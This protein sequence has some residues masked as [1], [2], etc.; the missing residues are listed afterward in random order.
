MPGQG[1]PPPS[2]MG[3]APPGAGGGPEGILQMLAGLQ[4]QPP[5]DGE[6]EALNDATMKLGMALSRI[7][8][9]SAKAAKL[10]A[11]AISKVQQAKEALAQEGQRGLQP[12][13]DLGL[14]GGGLSG[15]PPANPMGGF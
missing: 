1:G 14:A 9:R 10:L 13:P 4:Q 12:P 15:A 2:P 6:K 11:D 5:P 8:L 3:P 7:Q